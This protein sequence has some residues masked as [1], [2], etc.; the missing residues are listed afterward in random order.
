MQKCKKQQKNGG[1]VKNEKN[2]T[3]NIQKQVLINQE[4]YSVLSV[5]KN[6]SSIL[7]KLYVAV[8]E[9]VFSQT[10]EKSMQKEEN[11]KEVFNL[12]IE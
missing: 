4:K 3:H 1:Q 2:G 5:A 11:R 6:V 10:T 9:N 12:K 8:K 7:Q